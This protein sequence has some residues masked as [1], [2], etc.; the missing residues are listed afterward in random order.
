M[1]SIWVIL[2]V[3]LGLAVGLAAG[4]LVQHRFDVQGS[5]QAVVRVPPSSETEKWEEQLTF[6]GDQINDSIGR[7]AIH[8]RVYY[9]LGNGLQS[10]ILA[11][12]LLATIM[13]AIQDPQKPSRMLK[14]GLVLSAGLVTALAGA[15]NIFHFSDQSVASFESMEQG[16]DFRARFDIARLGSRTPQD[17]QA[18][19]R[20]YS[21]QLWDLDSRWM[22]TV[23]GPLQLQPAGRPLE[24]T[25][26]TRAQ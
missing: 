10:I 15:S 23:Y 8:G 1:R 22:K 4:A 2:L 9:W 20:E 25:Q 13:A 24:D 7:Y 12:G 19:Q 5:S 6:L 14:F 16:N 21:V 17:M 26:L 18:V 11:L 3:V